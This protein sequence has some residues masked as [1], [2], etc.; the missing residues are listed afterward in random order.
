MRLKVKAHIAG[1]MSDLQIWVE[2]NNGKVFT[3]EDQIVKTIG[4]E[5][6]DYLVGNGI[7]EQDPRGYRV[8]SPDQGQIPESWT[9]R[10]PGSVISANE[11]TFESWW[12]SLQEEWNDKDYRDICY[13]IGDIYEGSCQASFD[14]TFR[15]STCVGA[16]RQYSGAITRGNNLLTKIADK[17]KTFGLSV[18]LNLCTL[19]RCKASDKF[20]D[21]NGDSPY[22]EYEQSIGG[23]VTGRISK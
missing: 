21:E 13:W 18:E 1:K 11:E 3:T 17:M 7:I 22:S 9:M 5:G 14:I 20:K 19:D 16:F 2:D 10:H 23:S 6:Y 15:R 4:K 12:A 8:N